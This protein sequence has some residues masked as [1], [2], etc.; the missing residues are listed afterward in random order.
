[1]KLKV[2]GGYQLTILL[3]RARELGE[4]LDHYYKQSKKIKT[5]RG[6]YKQIN[7]SWYGGN[8]AVYC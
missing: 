1:M 7:L 5:V 6:L 3:A 4:Q 2:T 8:F